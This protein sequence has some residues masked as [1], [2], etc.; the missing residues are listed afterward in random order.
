MHHSA[1]MLLDQDIQ[2]KANVVIKWTYPNTTYVRNVKLIKL[3]GWGSL[4]VRASFYEANRPNIND[5]LLR[6]RRMWT[7]TIYK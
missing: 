3:H 2:C 5:T 4:S 7:W 1:C 6:C